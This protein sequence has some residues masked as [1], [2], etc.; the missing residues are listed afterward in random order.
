MVALESYIS[1]YL[2][3]PSLVQ[4]PSYAY[5]QLITIDRYGITIIIILG[6]YRKKHWVL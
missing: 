4:T 6:A 1:L 2:K 3:S 5:L